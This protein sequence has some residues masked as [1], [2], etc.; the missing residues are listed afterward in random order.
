MVRRE[1]PAS[2]DDDAEDLLFRGFGEA[3]DDEGELMEMVGLGRRRSIT[4]LRLR[5]AWARLAAMVSGEGGSPKMKNLMKAPM[6]ITMEIWPRRKP[7]M[8]ESLFYVLPLVSL[9]RG[10]GKRQD[11]MQYRPGLGMQRRIAGLTISHKE[12]IGGEQRIPKPVCKV[13]MEVQE[14]VN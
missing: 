3:K 14:K 7:D 13:M 4:R 11:L 12:I 1:A 6:R 10:D 8:K 2:C 5:K 9:R